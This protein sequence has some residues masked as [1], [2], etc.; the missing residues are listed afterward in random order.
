MTEDINELWEYACSGNTDALKEYYD[1]GGSIN[2][3]YIKFGRGHSL[4]MGAFRNNHFETV[5]YLMSVG[6]ELTKEEYNEFKTEM[7]KQELIERMVSQSEPD[8]SMNDIQMM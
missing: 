4:L 1:E 2:N 7:I 5:E 8:L 3:R 6:E